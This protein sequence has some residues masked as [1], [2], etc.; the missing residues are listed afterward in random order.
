[1]PAPHGIL[2]KTGKAGLPLARLG[3]PR[4]GEKGGM[5]RLL[6][7]PRA[8]ARKQLGTLEAFVTF[9]Q[10]LA[11][12]LELIGQRV[13]ISAAGIDGD[14]PMALPITGTLAGGTARSR[15]R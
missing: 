2:S 7:A 15:S 13:S 11:A 4:D 8:G 1:M 5:G 14:P 12:L 10:T 9:N 6:Q 3:P